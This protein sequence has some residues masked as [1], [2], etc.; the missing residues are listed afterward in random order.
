MWIKVNLLTYLRMLF[1]ADS[2]RHHGGL[3][4]NLVPGY[5]KL[6]EI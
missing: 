1:S 3:Q 5:G 6:D 2:K 4:G